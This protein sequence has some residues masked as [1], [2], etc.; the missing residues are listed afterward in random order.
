MENIKFV[1]FDEV[2]MNFLNA[3]ASKMPK[4]FM[5]G[6]E[7]FYFEN[8]RI[9]KGLVVGILDEGYEVKAS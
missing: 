7:I 9:N 1:L 2:I 5:V 6:E 3:V 8:N 4:D